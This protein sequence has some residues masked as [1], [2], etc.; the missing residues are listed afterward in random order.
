MIAIPP[1]RPELF[2][3]RSHSPAPELELAS[4]RLQIDAL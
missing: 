4:Y 2:Y 3:V 1:D